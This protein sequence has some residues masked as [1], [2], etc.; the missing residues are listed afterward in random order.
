MVVTKQMFSAQYIWK[1]LNERTTWRRLTI[2]SDLRSSR[3]AHSA[4]YAVSRLRG[5]PIA[6]QPTDQHAF[7]DSRSSSPVKLFNAAHDSI[8]SAPLHWAPCLHATGSSAI[9]KRDFSCIYKSFFLFVLFELPLQQVDFFKPGGE[10][11]VVRQAELAVH[12]CVHRL[13][14]VSKCAVSWDTRAKECC[15]QGHACAM[16]CAGKATYVQST[17]DHKRCGVHMSAA[18][19]AACFAWQ[20]ACQQK[21]LL[22][23]C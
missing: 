12:V 11:D 21:A 1:S 18:L 5:C 16:S 4:R 10:V 23:E 13:A 8:C 3:D 20:H 17:T 7:P 19:L 6:D 22:H 14:Q 2:I 15:L 9:V